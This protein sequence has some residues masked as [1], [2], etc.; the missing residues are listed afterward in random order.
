MSAPLNG[1]EILDLGTLTPGKF[2]TFLL[3]D[4][5]ASVLRIER[6]L[7][8]PV[9]LSDED[10]LLNRNK[11]SMTLNLR[12]DS[13]REIF[14]RLAQRADV[15]IEAYRPGV[16][17]RIGIDYERLRPENDRLV[18]C[19][20]SG[21]GQEGPN[22]LRP[23]YDLVFMGMSGVLQALVG[24]GNDP[25]V[26]RTYIA[27]AVSG[28]VAA[29]GIAV[30]LVRRE[31][32]RRGGHLDLAM[33]DSIFSTLSV[34]H[35]LRRGP[36]DVPGAEAEATAESAL[37]TT[38]ETSDSRRVV[39]GAAR[40]A[41]CR[42]LFQELGRP[43]LAERA[44]SSGGRDS[45]LSQFLGERFKGQTAAHW[46]ER[47]TKLDVE[48]APVNTPAE[49]FAEPQLV[50]RGM[51][52]ETS[53][54]EAGTLQQIGSSIQFAGESPSGEPAPAPTIGQNTDEVLRELGY[55]SAGISSLRAA[56]VV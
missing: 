34:S 47:L 17:T 6:P 36:D 10:L 29:L 55:D 39:L 20:L 42:A 31:K 28:L 48:I 40:E 5:G 56:G 26:P 22:R 9:A 44:W 18:Y 41:S 11:R 3:A 4:L 46:V 24:A 25:I 16:A 19:S 43:E 35:G 27:D 30:A 45:E 51:V 1:F 15:V 50:E 12:E 53:H 54:P 32:S 21:F 33:L 37:Y 38:Y 2:C 49:A 7:K 52:I 14:C 13:G 8:H 23:A